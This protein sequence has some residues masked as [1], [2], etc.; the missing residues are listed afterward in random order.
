MDTHGRDCRNAILGFAGAW[1]LASCGGGGGGAASPTLTGP[2]V[3]GNGFAPTAGSGDT[4]AY[5]PNAAGDQW[6]FNY[7]TTDASAA[8]PFGVT[9]L[10]VN[11]TKAIQGATATVFTFTNPTAASGGY[12]EYL[13]YSGGGVTA[14]GNT[15]PTDIL[16]PSIVPYVQML[17]PVQLGQV[18]SLTGQDLP[19]GH[20]ASGHPVTYDLTQTIENV[21]FEPVDVP[22][23]SFANALKQTTTISGTATD[24]GQSVAFSGT[25]T[26]WFVPGIGQVKDSTTAASNGTTISTSA[27][28]RGYGVNGRQHGLGPIGDVVA[29]L[30]PDGCQAAQAGVPAVGSDGSDFLVVAD[31]CAVTNGVVTTNWTGTL[32]GPDGT[33]GATFPITTPAAPNSSGPGILHAAVAFD[34]TN[35][36]VAFE[37]DRT[38][39]G[40]A[41]IDTVVVSRNGSIVA[42]PTT[43]ELSQYDGMN[44]SNNEALAFDGANYLLVYGAAYLGLVDGP[45]LAG[46][47]L[48]PSTGLP[49]GAPFP[50]STTAG[51]EHTNPAVAFDGTHFLVAW[52]EAGTT[53]SGLNAV[54]VA[55]SG[56]ILDASPIRLFDGS[57]S[58]VTQPCC[59]LEPTVS[60]DGTNYLVAYRDQRGAGN[61]AGDASVS[62]ARVSTAGA[63]LD[64]SATTP[65]IVVSSSKTQPVGRVRSVFSNGVHWIVW[66]SGSMQQLSGARVS[67]AGAVSG[68][69]AAGMTVVPAQNVTEYPA[70]G[71]SSTGAYLAWLRRAPAPSTLT[72]LAGLPIFS[73]GP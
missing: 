28:L 34:G 24:Q 14:L 30:E 60:F 55:T 58:D 48:S 71:A 53:P 43:I 56:A 41:Y 67:P 13:G 36:L 2:T 4:S 29:T 32:V 31:A 63:L 51:G 8:A 50:I 40:G 70:I 35:Y 65:G 6:R 42:G 11:G 54:R 64:G 46:V 19:G 1:V 59:D 27:E 10:A 23:G 52:V 73:S 68:T 62:A 20:D 18:S 39:A 9:E 26:A 45:Q 22:A 12:D 69:W 37:D 3:S 7:T 16:S 33:V 57:A 44:Y 21:D 61:T 66:E 47:F 5:L 17:F 72:A 38:L 15:D 49:N 25:D